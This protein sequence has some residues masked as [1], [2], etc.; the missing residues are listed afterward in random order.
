MYVHIF[1][2]HFIVIDIIQWRWHDGCQCHGV[3]AL[4]DQGIARSLKTHRS[5]C[6]GAT[7]ARQWSAKVNFQG[8]IDQ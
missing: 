1:I 8:S 3:N 7:S 5:R 2:L 6:K 4:M